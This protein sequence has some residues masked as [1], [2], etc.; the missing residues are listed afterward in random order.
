MTDTDRGQVSS[1]AAEIYESFFVPALFRDWA[2]RVADAARIGVG[3]RVLDVAC[4]TGVLSRT[5][6]ERVGGTGSVVG[7]DVNPAM[8]AVA[9]RTSAEVEWREAAAE[10]LPFE[11]G[12]FD[13]AVSQFGLMFFRDRVAALAEMMRVLRSGGRLAV[14]V[15]DSL[16]KTPGYAAVTRLLE[17]LFGAEV[18]DLLRAPYALGDARLLME[19]VRAAGVPEPRLE[20]ATGTARF[21][22]LEAWMHTDVRGWTLADRIDESGFRTLLSHAQRE[23]RQ[24]VDADGRV[25]FPAPAHIVTAL[26]G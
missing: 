26:K 1:S 3:E 9:R 22:S 19:T 25:S 15:W 2:V 11:S 6:R 14:A 4:G 10:A 18:A 12:S 8:L 23:L 5:A 21:A 20:T 7:V 24:F 13:V 16:E 17:R